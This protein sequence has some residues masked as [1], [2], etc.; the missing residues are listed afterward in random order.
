MG[1]IIIGTRI[2][3]EPG[4]GSPCYSKLDR[5]VRLGL[6][7]GDLLV[8]ATDAANFNA[9]SALETVRDAA[10]RLI[11]ADSDPSNNF[12]RPLNHILDIAL[13]HRAH[14]LIYQSIEIDVRSDQIET[15]KDH[16]DEHTLVV[17]A[18]I[19]DNHGSAPGVVPLSGWDSPWN[20]LALW[21]PQKLGMIGFPTISGGLLADLP[22]GAEEVAVIS[23]LQ[24]LFSKS[25]QA[26]LVDVGPVH[27]DVN[28]ESVLRSRYHEEKL[29]SKS[30]RAA[31]QVEV[32]GL[33]PGIV[34]IL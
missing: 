12:V 15:L 32:L 28:F 9:I 4:G 25:Y 17:G 2:Y 8:I 3:N 11:I 6:E 30:R 34:S 31:R 1:K 13:S 22:G 29:R 19:V 20:T 23:L 26:K 10:D 21:N 24:K 18:K 7:H 27:W 14:G 33:S 5:W 16:L